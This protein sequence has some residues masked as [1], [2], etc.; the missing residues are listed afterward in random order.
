M[1][2]TYKWLPSWAEQGEEGTWHGFAR[3]EEKDEKYRKADWKE[4][5]D[6]RHL[7]IFDLNPFKS[8]LNELQKP[9]KLIW[10]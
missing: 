7:L 3:K 4:P 2:N 1:N 10:I 5:E 9:Y 6:K 8:S